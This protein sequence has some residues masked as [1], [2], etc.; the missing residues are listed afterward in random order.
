M[1][2]LLIKS[3]F[4]EKKRKNILLVFTAAIFILSM[5]SLF[6]KD[7]VKSS[8]KENLKKIKEETKLFAK[9]QNREAKTILESLFLTGNFQYTL[10]IFFQR[11][12]GGR[13]LIMNLQRKRQTNKN[14]LPLKQVFKKSSIPP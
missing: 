13:A 11:K 1:K 2:R 12:I 10:T 9:E 5:P 8:V 6:A 4:G 14:F 7:T 3:C